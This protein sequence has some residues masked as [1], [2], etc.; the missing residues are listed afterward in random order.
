MLDRLIEIEKRKQ[1]IAGNLPKLSFEKASLLKKRLLAEKDT[2]LADFQRVSPIKSFWRAPNL[3]IWMTTGIAALLLIGIGVVFTRKTSHVTETSVTY[4]KGNVM[5]NERLL[6]IGTNLVPGSTISTGNLSLALLGQDRAVTTIIGQGSKLRIEK[7]YNLDG[8]SKIYWENQIGTIFCKVAK[9]RAQVNIATPSAII[10]VIGTSFSVFTD[11]HGTAIHVLE[12]L[13]QVNPNDIFI[14]KRQNKGK[15]YKPAK[16]LQVHAGEKAYI[17]EATY[18]IATTP[19]SSKEL[20]LLQKF[21]ELATFAESMPQE[22]TPTPKSR[23]DQM[24]NSI[25]NAGTNLKTKNETA[26]KSKITLTL[27]DIRRK[28]GKISR[29]NLINGDSYVGFFTMRGNQVQ[30][31][32]PKGTIRVSR[33]MLKDVRAAE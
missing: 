31:I 2:I 8:H 27:A 12:G 17:S 13:V 7:S 28:Y 32:T 26:T 15:P 22:Q 16:P 19:L 6:Q 5:V 18:Q 29:V 9:G 14:R 4:L 11:V 20:R 30:I 25:F 23:F 3:K 1:G 10:T 24:V 33:D 21:H